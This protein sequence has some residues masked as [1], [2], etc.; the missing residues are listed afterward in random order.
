MN[1]PAPRGHT[2]QAG[3]R[4][5][6]AP[7]IPLQ[8]RVIEP[9]TASAP[10]TLECIDPRAPLFA[11]LRAEWAAHGSRTTRKYLELEQRIAA[12]TATMAEHTTAH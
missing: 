1:R 2:I 10:P 9:A 12:L 4:P 11:Q 5:G 7:S 3:Q 8:Y 6:E